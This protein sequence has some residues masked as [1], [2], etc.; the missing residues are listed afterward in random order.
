MTSSSSRKSLVSNDRVRDLGLVQS[1]SASI[2]CS[3]NIDI[4]SE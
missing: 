2:D 1:L 4:V 3:S